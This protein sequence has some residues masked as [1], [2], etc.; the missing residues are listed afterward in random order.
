ME[1]VLYAALITEMAL[2]M[3]T[4]RI[5]EGQESANH[6]YP[7][8]VRLGGGGAGLVCG[9]SIICPTFVMTAAHCLDFGGAV[10]VKLVVVLAGM[11]RLDDPGTERHVV[12]RAIIHPKY[13]TNYTMSRYDF[14]ILELRT[15]ISIRPETSPIYLPLPN[16]PELNIRGTRF[17]ASGWGYTKWSPDYIPPDLQVVSMYQHNSS[18]CPVHPDEFCA[19]GGGWTCKGDSG[20]PLAW[21]DPST[22][23]VKLIGMTS[24]GDSEICSEKT[25]TVFARVP[26]VVKWINQNTQG[27]NQNIC[28]EDK[29]MTRDKLK[30]Q[31]KLMMQK[32]TP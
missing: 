28:S 7:W 6:A 31:A 8:Q 18:Y 2:S 27:C 14:A 30:P 5:Y 1:L 17:A 15:P 16:E 9:G 21:I 10:N 23:E 4:N 32:Q 22:S 20:G 3:R 26:T 25:K 11:N 12:K 13:W 24:R 29:C 19:G